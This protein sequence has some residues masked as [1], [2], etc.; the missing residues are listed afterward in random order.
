V[1]TVELVLP[2]ISILAGLD[3]EAL[4]LLAREAHRSVFP[5]GELITREGESGNRLFMIESGRVRIFKK[6][7]SDGGEVELALLGAN[8]SFGEGCILTALP[9]AASAQAVA[10]TILYSLSSMAFYHLYHAL[11]AQYGI[12]ILNIA[13]DLARQLRRLDERFAACH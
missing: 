7:A 11:P 9:R 6:C 10:D 3:E 12:L 1:E 2:P 8:D 13:R 4:D 5:T